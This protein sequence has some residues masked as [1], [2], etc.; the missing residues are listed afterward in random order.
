MWVGGK[1]IGDTRF[2]SFSTPDL[3]LS[4]M[5]GPVVLALLLGVVSG[6][7]TSLAVA[8]GSIPAAAA[9][10]YALFYAPPSDGEP[11]GRSDP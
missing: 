11:P 7:P 10:G 2:G 4:F 6:V 8:V 5:P 9:M 1:T 3:V